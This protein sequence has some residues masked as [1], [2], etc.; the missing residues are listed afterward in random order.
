MLC[1]LSQ[2][3]QK[4]KD[5]YDVILNEKKE[6]NSQL[7]LLNETVKDYEALLANKVE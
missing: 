5:S 3:Y 7:E 6:Y 1:R 4:L 2:E